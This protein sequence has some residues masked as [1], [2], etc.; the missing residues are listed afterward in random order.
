MNK[1][2][3]LIFAFFIAMNS[4]AQSY[5]GFLT[6]NYNGIHGVISNPANIADSK[7]KLDINLAGASALFG[8]DFYGFDAKKLLDESY[9]IENDAKKFP[10]SENNIFG[11]IDVLGPSALININKKSAFAITTRLRSFYNINSFNGSQIEELENG[12]D[13]GQDFN[14]NQNKTFI[15]TNTWAEI[16]F[17]Y[18]SILIQENQHF[19]KGGFTFKYLQGLGNAYATTNNLAINYDADETVVGANAPGSV[20]TDGDF[21]YG[22][23]ENFKENTDDISTVSGARALGLDVGLIYEWRPNELSRNYT[24]YN[25]YKLKL[26]LSVTDIGSITYDNIEERYN[27]SEAGPVSQENFESIKNAEDLRLFYDISSTGQTEK[28]VLPTALHFNADWNLNQ[29]F[30]LNLNTDLSLT[31]KSKL[32]RNRVANMVTLT[33][34]FESKWF[35]MQ[36]PISYQQHSGLNLGAGLRAGPIYIGSGSGISALLKKDTKAI[37]VYVGIKIGLF[38]PQSKD[39]DKDG[40]PDKVDGCIDEFGAIDNNGCPWEDSDGD[41]IYDNEDD[42]PDMRGD[43]DNNGCPKLTYEIQKTL[44][45]KA[46]VILF[47][48]NKTEI[49]DKT[50]EALMGVI[51]ILNQYPYA[52]LSIEGHAD[53]I[54]NSKLNQ[55]VS[56]MR[57]NAVRNFL[58]QKGIDAS[59][60]TA[61]G[62]GE[63]IPIATNLTRKGRAQ[64]RRVEIKLEQD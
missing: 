44:N 3:L 42:C 64:N 9:T 46:E 15:S 35:T 56:E 34:R 54:G 59:R 16:G 5:V 55:K 8:N 50:A 47:N 58:I 37:D 36:A 13:I 27:L 18:S 38:K 33:P 22:Y 31:K 49:T 45:A 63:N 19:F 6:D 52:K 11:N 40:V 23:S 21:T 10:K 26:G 28:A 17:T 62:Y 12:F 53:S 57:A 25:K 60:L 14:I 51:D 20:T 43:A 41:G 29:K 39:Q 7:Y 61:I 1:N 2:H 32:N 48:S 30:Y 4:M 24:G